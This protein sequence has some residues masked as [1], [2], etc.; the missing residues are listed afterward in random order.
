[1]NDLYT[2]CR[3]NVKYKEEK[4]RNELKKQL[5]KNKKEAIIACDYLYNFLI[6]DKFLK[7]KIK[8]ASFNG[9][10]RYI[11]YKYSI[12]DRIFI[13]KILRSFNINTLLNGSK[14]PDIGTI[15]R[16]GIEPVYSRFENYIKPFKSKLLKSDNTKYIEISW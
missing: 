16:F 11:I 12:T 5:D 10:N 15:M 9:L 6:S 13:P 8:K 4:R 3:N 7:N 14:G 2:E 1:M